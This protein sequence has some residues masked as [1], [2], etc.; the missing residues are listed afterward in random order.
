MLAFSDVAL[1]CSG[2][3]VLA[4]R[5]GA[6]DVDAEDRSYEDDLEE[7]AN[8]PTLALLSSFF[9]DIALSYPSEDFARNDA[10]SRVFWVDHIRDS[11]KYRA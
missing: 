2:S 7:D 4:F 8:E 3:T 9:E 10:K 11:K 5:L 1:L 6:L